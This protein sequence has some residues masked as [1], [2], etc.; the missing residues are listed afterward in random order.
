MILLPVLSAFSMAS[1]CNRVHLAVHAWM[2]HE[3]NYVIDSM[4]IAETFN[5]EFAKNF[6]HTSPITIAIN[7][8]S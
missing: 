6:S 8:G 1:S 3:G 5:S 2:V 4:A 7:L